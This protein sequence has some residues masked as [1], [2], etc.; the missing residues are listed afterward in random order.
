[1]VVEQIARRYHLVTALYEA[2]ESL[3]SIFNPIGFIFQS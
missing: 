3:F 1:M 2:K